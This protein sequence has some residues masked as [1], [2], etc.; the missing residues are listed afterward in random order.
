MAIKFGISN[1]AALFAAAALCFLISS[2][3]S[4]SAAPITVV[5]GPTTYIVVHLNSVLGTSSLAFGLAACI[6]WVYTGILKHQADQLLVTVHFTLNIIGVFG[7]VALF[8]LSRGLLTF[9]I[10]VIAIAAVVLAAQIIFL[11]SLVSGLLRNSS[12]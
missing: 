2:I 11:I 8:W 6:Y 10:A 3:L 12:Q 1:P 9:W 4:V 7:T 5:Y